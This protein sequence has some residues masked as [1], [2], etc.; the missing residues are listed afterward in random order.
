MSAEI[1]SFQ[2]IAIGAIANAERAEDWPSALA[3]V[4]ALA[5]R[6]KRKKPSVKIRAYQHPTA[7]DCV[8][9]DKRAYANPIELVALDDV[10]DLLGWTEKGISEWRTM[11]LELRSKIKP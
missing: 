7:P 9:S 5:D 2:K 4:Y 3:M 11:Y 6:R 1:T 10:A 8:C